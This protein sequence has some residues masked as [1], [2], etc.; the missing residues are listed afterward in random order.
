MSQSVRRYVYL[1]CLSAYLYKCYM[2]CKYLHV[3]SNPSKQPTN[4]KKKNVFRYFHVTLP[5]SKYIL[6]CSNSQRSH[7][8][9]WRLNLMPA[10]LNVPN[11]H[12]GCPAVYMCVCL[13][14]LIFSIW[15]RNLHGVSSTADSARKPTN[16]KCLSE[17][18]PIF[19]FVLFYFPS[20][21]VICS[22]KNEDDKNKIKN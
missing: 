15:H 7:V 17:K 11:W 22:N 8:N 19:F 6:R 9:V 4:N 10:K 1:V 20:L 2:K 3:A 16:I 14:M 18:K 21:N 5:L 12:P 13:S